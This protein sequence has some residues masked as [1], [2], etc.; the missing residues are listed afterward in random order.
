MSVRNI[1]KSAAQEGGRP[2]YIYYK[3]EA[4]PNLVRQAFPS[5]CCVVI[6]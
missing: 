4:L 6:M 2:R 1:K 3:D 5:C